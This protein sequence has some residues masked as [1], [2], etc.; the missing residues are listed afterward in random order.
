M[1]WIINEKL[2]RPFVF[3]GCVLILSVSMM[4]INVCLRLL[5]YA[6]ASRKTDW[7][8]NSMDLQIE[9]VNYFLQRSES[10]AMTIG[11]AACLVI[12]FSIF[13]LAVFRKMLTEEKRKIIGVYFAY[14]YKKKILWKLLNADRMIYLLFSIPPAILMTMGMMSLC[15][16]REEF[17]FIIFAGGNYGITGLFSI[18]CS[19]LFVWTVMDSA[20]RYCM[21]KIM[22]ESTIWLIK[23]NR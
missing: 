12:G 4:M 7:Y 23:E 17:R 13:V 20:D 14:G 6:L 21:N 8:H 18:L 10:V 16:R 1:N 19:I 3:A 2:R 22:N 11:V 5:F 15:E 9:N